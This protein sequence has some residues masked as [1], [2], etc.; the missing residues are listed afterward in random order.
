MAKY[1][2]RLG[3]MHGDSLKRSRIKDAAKS[4]W[5][6]KNRVKGTVCPDSIDLKMDLINDRFRVCINRFMFKN[7][8]LVLNFEISPQQLK[9]TV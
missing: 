2:Q 7:I 1:L 5:K 9:G 8:I 4:T 6:R 3:G